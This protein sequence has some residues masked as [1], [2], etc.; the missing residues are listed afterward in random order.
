MKKETK[1]KIREIVLPRE[2]KW[3]RVIALGVAILVVLLLLQVVAASGV[4]LRSNEV[5]HY[6]RIYDAEGRYLDP[7]VPAV[8]EYLQVDIYKSNQKTLI[9]ETK[10]Q[11]NISFQSDEGYAFVKI[12]WVN[13]GNPIYMS[14]IPLSNTYVKLS[15]PFNP[16]KP[17]ENW[18]AE[19][20]SISASGKSISTPF[21]GVTFGV[22]DNKNII[23][24]TIGS[25][26]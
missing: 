15:L 5:T 3:K 13:K 10:G 23:Q 11:N 8:K 17:I 1:E 6:L 9:S 24:L 14:T 22:G 4:K 7:K 25:K 26:T 2:I 16:A 19:A 20:L 18:Q 12:F 21:Y